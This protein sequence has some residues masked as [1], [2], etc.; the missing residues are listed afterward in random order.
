MSRNHPSDEVGKS[1]TYPVG[2]YRPKESLADQVLEGQANLL[3]MLE[4][5]QLTEEEKLLVERVTPEVV[6]M[7]I[8]MQDEMVSRAAEAQRLRQRPRRTCAI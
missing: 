8:A 3:R 2:F 6:A 5:V 4:F 7:T 1:Y